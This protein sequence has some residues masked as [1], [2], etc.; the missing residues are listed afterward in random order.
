MPRVYTTNYPPEGELVAMMKRLGSYSKVAAEL[1]VSRKSLEPYVRRRPG[2]KA[3]MDE[4]AVAPGPGRKTHSTD[5][6]LRKARLRASRKYSAK[7]QR[8]NPDRKRE[9]N[10]TWAK[11]QAP[12]KRAGWNAY[13]RERLRD[14][15]LGDVP[16]HLY[17]DPC[18]Y[19]G[20]PGG[21][22]DHIV[23]I[24]TG[25]STEAD[26]LTAACQPCDSSKNAGACSTTCRARKAALKSSEKRGVR[27][28][29]PP[30]TA[31]PPFRDS[32]KWFGAKKNP[33]AGRMWRTA[34]GYLGGRRCL[35][36]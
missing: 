15:R 20:G 4:F 30:G 24:H 6:E 17:L 11:N 22:V 32:V 25:G 9:I 5:E 21:T 28:G 7:M 27:S 18:S 3:R 31:S 8:E 1:G 36:R 2:L 23:P 26:N 10:R 19:C 29:T 12:E 16:A 34:G 13:N 33:P 35:R 14:K